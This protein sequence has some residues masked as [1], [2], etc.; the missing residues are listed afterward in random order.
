MTV[1]YRGP[2]ALITHKVI[3]V[4]YVARRSFLIRELSSVHI[5]H[6]APTGRLSQHRLLSAAALASMFLTVPVAGQASGV[7]AGL[8]V[9]ASMICAGACLRIKEVV[10]YDLVAIQRGRLVVVFS[11]SDLREFE[12][13]CRAVRRALELSS[14][15]T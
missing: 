5:V 15:T 14:D 1:F 13:V 6:T 3:E 2:R 7:L 12:Q 9:V 11:S 8:I 4:P 10:R